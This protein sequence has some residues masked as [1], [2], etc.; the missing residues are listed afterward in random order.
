MTSDVV[1]RPRIR[2]GEETG[3]MLQLLFCMGLVVVTWFALGFRPSFSAMGNDA[4]KL[5][6]PILSILHDVHG[7]WRAMVYRPE[8]FGGSNLLGLRGVL[9]TSVLLTKVGFSPL[10]TLNIDLFFAQAMIGFLGIQATR[11]IARRP[12]SFSSM[13]DMLVSACLLW[14]LGFGPLMS[15]RVNLG[16]LNLIYGLAAFA[17]L[18]TVWISVASHR[19]TRVVAVVALVT[20]VQAFCTQGFQVLVMGAIFGVPIIA[21]LALTEPVMTPARIMR[22]TVISVVFAGLALLIAAPVFIAMFDFATGMDATRELAHDVDIYSYMVAGWREFAESL[23]WFGHH[24]SR[25]THSRPMESR[26]GLGPLLIL[27][28]VF[29]N[30][31]S[32]PVVTGLLISLAMAVM[33]VADSQPVSGWLL[34]I[35]VV[36]DFRVPIRSFIP[37]TWLVTVLVC[38]EVSGRLERAGMT[39]DGVT[40]LTIV[41]GLALVLTLPPTGKEIFL[42][43]L[44]A[45]MSLAIVTRRMQRMTA[46]AGIIVIVDLMAFSMNIDMDRHAEA[47]L[48]ANR[49]FGQSV[50][51][52]YPQLKMPLN[53]IDVDMDDFNLDASP[54]G[55]LTSIAGYGFPHRQ[56]SI[57]IHDLVGVRFSSTRSYFNPNART[58]NFDV[59]RQLYN[60]RDRLEWVNKSQAALIP[61]GPTPGPV[62]ASSRRVVMADQHQLDDTLIETIR[63]PDWQNL[64]YVTR[65][66]LALAPV[67]ECRRLEFASPQ[68][69]QHDTRFD[70]AVGGKAVQPCPVTI[71]MTWSSNLFG[72]ARVAGK[73]VPFSL[74]PAYGA[75]VGFSLPTGAASFTIAAG[76]HHYSLSLVLSALGLLF[77]IVLILLGVRAMEPDR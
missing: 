33:L 59:A 9:P 54:V 71:S 57:L 12:S 34:H 11:I 63:Q 29:V 64:Q 47:M 10:W 15:W 75:L 69:S 31:R 38:G 50:I 43:V 26:Y 51:S 17:A 42:W 53:R 46:F 76:L 58:R 14:L 67:Y 60:I 18:V 56:F 13:R 30:R 65:P 61:L 2:A 21:G 40:W 32:W 73:Q 19:L 62:W 66:Q 55:K 24:I 3:Q 68:V 8:Y 41:A 44:A 28:F 49:A 37:L 52:R 22:A 20:L 70:V 72:V 4:G 5:F 7:D 35:P 27:T 1:A 36:S 39:A 6:L 45:V 16:H 25:L 77:A 23:M 48:Q 74:Y